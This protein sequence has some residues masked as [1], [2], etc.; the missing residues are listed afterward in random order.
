M[1][2]RGHQIDGL[3][4]A[5]ERER[6]GFTQAECAARLGVHRVTLTKI[7]NDD[8]NVSLDLIERM[9]ALFSCTRE[10]LQGLDVPVDEVEAAKEQIAEALAKVSDGLEDLVDVMADLNQR[11][12]DVAAHKVAV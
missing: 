8:T 9:T 4:A 11:V 12:H 10:H 2:K 6:L 3:R 7:E 1:S 5:Q